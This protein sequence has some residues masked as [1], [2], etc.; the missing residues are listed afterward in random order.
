[1][2]RRLIEKFRAWMRGERRIAP[3]KVRGRVYEKKA[4]PADSGNN[5]ISGRGS[6]SMKMKVIRNG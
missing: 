6:A 1:M 5:I 4:R 3:A 2:F